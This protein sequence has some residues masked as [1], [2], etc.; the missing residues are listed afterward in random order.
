MYMHYW[1][2]SE[3]GKWNYTWIDRHTDAKALEYI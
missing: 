3:G 2:L 1:Q